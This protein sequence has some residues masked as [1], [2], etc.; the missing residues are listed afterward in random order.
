MSSKN[1][2]QCPDKSGLSV[3][4]LP[5]YALSLTINLLNILAPELLG[6]EIQITIK[7]PILYPI[8]YCQVYRMLHPSYLLNPAYLSILSTQPYLISDSFLPQKNTLDMFPRTHIEG[9][10]RVDRF[11]FIL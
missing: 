4:M 9:L 3:Q 2:N 8:L 1:R 5:E 7:V 6:M 10:G 11:T